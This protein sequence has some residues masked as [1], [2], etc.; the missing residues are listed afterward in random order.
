[1]R[2]SQIKFPRATFQPN[3]TNACNKYELI[4]WAEEKRKL[5]EHELSN[6]YLCYRNYSIISELCR[7]GIASIIVFLLGLWV[8]THYI[9]TGMTVGFILSCRKIT[10]LSIILGISMLALLLLDRAS[11]VEYRRDYCVYALLETMTVRFLLGDIL[12]EELMVYSLLPVEGKNL[13]RSRRYADCYYHFCSLR[14]NYVSGEITEKRYLRGLNR[15]LR[16]LHKRERRN[17][18]E[19]VDSLK[20]MLE[21]CT[22]FY[23]TAVNKGLFDRDEVYIYL[24]FLD[25]LIG[26]GT[27]TDRIQGIML[28]N[29]EYKADDLLFNVLYAIIDI[30]AVIRV[31]ALMAMHEK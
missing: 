5:F 1:M 23:E 21:E 26:E 12:N 27:D 22:N 18:Q 6:E 28:N 30:G 10:I 9:A 7:V 17:V 11:N 29:A 16:F 24:L 13:I 20:G 31:G 15:M 2:Y 8:Y 14:A 25:S 19:Y 3:S 4:H